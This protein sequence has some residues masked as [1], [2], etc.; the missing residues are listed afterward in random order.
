[1]KR[2]LLVIS[3]LALTACTVTVQSVSRP[4][5][6][7]QAWVPETIAIEAGTTVRH[8]VGEAP[9]KINTAIVKALWRLR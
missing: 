1:V 8:D 6:V 3:L 9:S 7:S 4:V 2:T 5:P